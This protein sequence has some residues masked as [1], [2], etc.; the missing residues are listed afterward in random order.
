VGNEFRD[1]ARLSSGPSAVAASTPRVDP[2]PDPA[3]ARADEGFWVAVL[4]FKHKG[5]DPSLDSLAEGLVEEIITGLSRFSYMRVISGGSSA[6]YAGESADVREI[7]KELGA[8]YVLEGNLRQ[9]DTRLRVT[10]QL[11]DTSSG[12]HLWAETYD[13]VFQP[14]AVFDLQD[15]LVPKIVSTTADA[16]GVLPR[17]MGESLRSRQAADL[18]PYEAVLRSFAYLYR[19]SAEEHRAA[20]EALELAV[21]RAPDYAPA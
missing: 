21:E 10:V 13:R 18:T 3:A 6:R 1:L 17:D 2:K 4:P 16:Q 9:A 14:N 15:E 5:A 19:I 11:L 8:R 7:G 12:A 20:R